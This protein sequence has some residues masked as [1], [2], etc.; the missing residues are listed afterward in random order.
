MI[1]GLMEAI[2]A[3]EEW[4]NGALCAQV[5]SELFFPEH[6][7][8][9]PR[10]AKRICAVCPVQAEC[11]EYALQH[12][13]QFGVWGGTTERERRRMRPRQPRRPA[14]HCARGHSY[15]KTGR[16][17]DAGCAE[18]KRISDRERSRERYTPKRRTA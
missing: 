3:R 5:D 8:K 15:A 17:G 1:V 12:R 11:L 7:G 16:R 9:S 10:A 18:Y 4:M 14:T 2:N 6:Q 13:E